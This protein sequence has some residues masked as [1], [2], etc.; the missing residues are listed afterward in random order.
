M[1]T[2]PWSFVIPA[3]ELNN[4]AKILPARRLDTSTTRYRDIAYPG[5]VV[6][7]GDVDV[8]DGWGTWVFILSGSSITDPTS[9]LIEFISRAE[10]I[11]KPTAVFATGTPYPANSREMDEIINISTQLPTIM[12][13]SDSPGFLSSIVAGAKARASALAYSAGVGMVNM[14]GRS[15]G[16]FI[17]SRPTN[18]V[19]EEVPLVRYPGY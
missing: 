12:T 7:L 15:V 16:R 14:M 1:L 13:E 19:R 11:P 9:I 10:I 3:S 5:A 4:D 17:K 6:P 2:L 18:W 8:S